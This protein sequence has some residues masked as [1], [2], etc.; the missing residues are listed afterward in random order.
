LT[1]E[2]PLGDQER[3][4]E[5]AEGHLSEGSSDAFGAPAISMGGT[6][7]LVPQMS[8]GGDLQV[9]SSG[10]RLTVGEF[11]S[12]KMAVFGL[13]VLVFFILFSFVGP[14]IY[15]TNQSLANPVTADLSPSGSHI[16]G[17]NEFGFD[18]L[19][20][21]MKG[22]QASLEIGAL[23]ALMAI[24][25]GTIFGAVSGLA[26][27]I[28]DWVMMRIVDVF[29]SIPFLLVVLVLATVWHLTILHMSMLLAAFS[30]Q[31]PARLV[32]GEVKTLRERDFVWA[33]RVM[34]AGSFRIVFRHLIP[35]AMAVTVVN[36]TFLI[37]DSILALAILGFL[38][39]GLSYPQTDWGDML[40]NALQY[41]NSGYWWLVYPVGFCLVFVVLAANLV[42]DGLRDALDVRLRRR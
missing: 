20:A 15:T 34:G 40:G 39:F 4:E 5:L 29:L 13:G 27:G 30:W 22:G 21:M 33:A 8:D 19:G 41:V 9:I 24:F 16:F 17:T 11:A 10:W 7:L 31:V 35:N 42:G 25:V 38:G 1:D 28:V 6:Q 18:Q 2:T 14:H 3:S 26:G 12:N 37:A 36:V 23:A 32:R